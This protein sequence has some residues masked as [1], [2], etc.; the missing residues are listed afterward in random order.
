MKVNYYLVKDEVHGIPVE[1]IA[2]SDINGLKGEFHP[3]ILS[4]KYN[5]I[6]IDITLEDET[7]D[8]NLNEEALQLIKLLDVPREILVIF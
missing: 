3:A 5:Y 7:A 2:S 4:P 8:I 1:V 6:F